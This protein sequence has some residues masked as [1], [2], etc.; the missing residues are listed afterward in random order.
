MPTLL[1]DASALLKRYQIELGSE[2]VN[3]LLETDPR[4]EMVATIWGYAE[5]YAVLVRSRNSGRIS[6]SAFEAAVSA[7]QNEVLLSGDFGLLSVDEAQVAAWLTFV[8]R[9]ALNS[10]D[11]AIL[12]AFVTFARSLPPG[13]PPCLLIAADQRLL[14]AAIAEGLRTLNPETTPAASV[15]GVLAE[16][17]ILL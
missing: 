17:S 14:R 10:N 9:Y 15:A 7:L 6:R 3:A 1:W 5:C 12:A 16:D 2:T 13:S 8:D 11:A 4:P